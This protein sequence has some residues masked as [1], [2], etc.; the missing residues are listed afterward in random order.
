IKPFIKISNKNPNLINI[1]NVDLETLK[2][3]PYIDWK[4]AK[5]IIAYRNS[6]GN[7]KDVDDIKQIHLVTDEIYTKIAPYLTVK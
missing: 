1:N 6:H 3:H 5:T 7:Y 4:I 2:K